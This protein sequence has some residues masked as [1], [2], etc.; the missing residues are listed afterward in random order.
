MKIFLKFLFVVPLLLWLTS[1]GVVDLAYNNA[2]SLVASKIDDAFAL[3][4]TQSEQLDSRLEQFFVWHRNEELSRYHQFL[5][6]AALDAADGITAAEFLSLREDVLAAWNRTVEKGVDSLGDLLANLTP[7]QIE[8]YQRYYDERSE[9]FLEYLEKSAQQREIYRVERS[10]KRLESWFGDF[11]FE[12]EQRITERL[13]RIPDIYEPWFEFREG[14]HQALVAAM[15]QG[16]TGEQLKTIMLDP[17]TDY[18]LAFA[19]AREAY[20]RENAAALEDISSWLDDNQR[21]RVVSRLQRF[22]RIVERLH[23]QG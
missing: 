19:P 11:D 14:R 7:E 8:Q 10:Y 6:R 15:Q 22:A 21:Q 12:L 13:R 20:W 4:E 2:P 17:S 23:A 5:E 16:L 18:A 1:C 3:D 9:E